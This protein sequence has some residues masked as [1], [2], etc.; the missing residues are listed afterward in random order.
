M[1]TFTFNDYILINI[2]RYINSGKDYKSVCLVSKQFYNIIN[3]LF[4]GGDKFANHLLTLLKLFPDENWDY[5]RMSK[6]PNITI[7]YIKA[8]LYKN[9]NFKQ[10][11]Q[12]SRFTLNDVL[13]N[14][15]IPWDYNSL[16]YNPNIPASYEEWEYMSNNN[17]I[18]DYLALIQNKSITWDIIINNLDKFSNYISDSPNITIDIIRNNPGLEWD[19]GAMSENP[20][21]ILDM[22]NEFIDK[23]W[24]FGTLMDNENITND[25][26]F[27]KF[28]INN[29]H[30]IDAFDLSYVVTPDITEKYP[31]LSWDNI[32]LS[33]NGNITF[34][35]AKKRYIVYKY[36]SINKNMNIDILL[37]NLDENWSYKRLSR[38]PS[39]KIADILNNLDLP[40]NIKELSDRKDLTWRIVQQH[41]ELFDFA[42]L[43]NNKFGYKK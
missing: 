12:N 37:N 18:S 16:Q 11:T 23:D 17:F 39:I 42:M 3:K 26:K 25:P 40:W 13:N 30:K 43:S 20:A 35:F 28:I 41:P 9:W 22:V 36:F 27:P 14:P 32:L 8:N 5:Q 31:D 6:N 1:F 7:E 19:F 34:Y 38:N 4:P 21:V 2:L 24:D 29:I 15:E 10:L 33:M